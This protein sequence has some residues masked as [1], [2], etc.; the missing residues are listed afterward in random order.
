MVVIYQKKEEDE[1]CQGDF[2]SL[3]DSE[4][5]EFFPYILKVEENEI[6]KFIIVSNT[7]DIQ[8]NNIKY[9]S[10]APIIELKPMLDDIAFKKKENGSKKEN[11]ESAIINFVKDLH[12]YNNKEYFYLPKNNRY[13][14]SEESIVLLEYILTKQIDDFMPFI[15]KKV[16][17]TLKPPWK[18]KLGWKMGYLYNRIALIDFPKDK[19]KKITSETIKTTFKE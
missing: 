3:T 18:E 16:K 2:F 6:K 5:D 17:Y 1:L 19:Y 8:Q 10:I 11:I 4:I 9:L 7:C 13:D 15:R 12:I 14:I